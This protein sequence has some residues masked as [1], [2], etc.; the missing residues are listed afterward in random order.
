VPD[1]PRVFKMP[2]GAV[3]DVQG[4]GKPATRAVI[5]TQNPGHV[6]F[7]DAHYG[8]RDRIP[9]PTARHDPW[10]ENERQR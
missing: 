1:E 6:F 9:V 8:V 2:Q 10:A 4:C 7:C 3:C 5:A